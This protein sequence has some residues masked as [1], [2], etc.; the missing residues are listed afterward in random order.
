MGKIT[1][2]NNYSTEGMGKITLGTNYSTGGMLITTQDTPPER[3]T[4]VTIF[5]QNL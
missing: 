4:T 2:G 1:Q 3:M 5:F